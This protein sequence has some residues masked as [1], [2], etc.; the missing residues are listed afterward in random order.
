MPA[1]ASTSLPGSFFLFS[2]SFPVVVDGCRKAEIRGETE[3]FSFNNADKYTLTQSL[4]RHT[5]RIRK[6]L[7][8][9]CYEL[10]PVFEQL[11]ARPSTLELYP[12]EVYGATKRPLNDTHAPSVSVLSMPHMA[13]SVYTLATER[14]KLMSYAYQASLVPPPQEGAAKAPAPAKASTTA[15]TSAA[16]TA[17]ATAAAH[18]DSE[19]EEESEETSKNAKDTD[20][21]NPEPVVAVPAATEAATTS[22]A[23]DTTE[24]SAVTTSSSSVAEA[25]ADV[26][27][28]DADEAG[29]SS[30]AAAAA[31]AP[32]V[33]DAGEVCF[34]LCLLFFLKFFLHLPSCRFL[35]VSF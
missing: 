35:G 29:S 9:S 13:A 21:A 23:M 3:I 11:L 18:Q 24:G 17:A 10:R 7:F 33:V 25:S 26:T 27:M 8:A 15:A 34:F 2:F 12:T 22:E 20:T 19:E 32:M 1:S 4:F 16:S 28:G 14:V 30:S 31:A 5:T 6:S